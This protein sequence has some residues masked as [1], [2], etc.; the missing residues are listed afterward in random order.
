MGKDLMSYDIAAPPGSPQAKGP[1][2]K[3]I[4]Q[5]LWED[6]DELVAQIMLPGDDFKKSQLKAEARGIS[7]ALALMMRPL[8]VDSR[9][10]SKESMIRY[11]KAQAGEEYQTPCV[12]SRWKENPSVMREVHVLGKKLE[13]VPGSSESHPVDRKR[14]IPAAVKTKHSTSIPTREKKAKVTLTDQQRSLIKA[15]NFADEDLA[16]MFKVPVSAIQDLRK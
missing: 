7:R 15:S 4:N 14:A 10:I 1:G 16:K 9:E 3:S 6:L 13:D 5:T 8:F 12:G 11:R 2:S